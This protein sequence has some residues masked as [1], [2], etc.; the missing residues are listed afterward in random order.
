MSKRH[1]AP[2]ATGVEIKRRNL[3][4]NPGVEY[5]EPRVYQENPIDYESQVHAGAGGG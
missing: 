3:G 2:A 1:F 5:V 4:V